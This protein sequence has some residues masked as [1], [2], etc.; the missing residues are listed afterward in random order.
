MFQKNKSTI[1]TI[2]GGVILILLIYALQSYLVPF[3]LAYVLAYVVDP[4][5][6]WIQEKGRVR[7][8]VLAVWVFLFG[9][10]GFVIGVG[11]LVAPLLL[12]EFD[13]LRS[14]VENENLLGNAEF[15]FVEELKPLLEEWLN[16]S[17]TQE[18][19]NS[20]NSS[21]LGEGMLGALEAVFSVFGGLLGGL[22]NAFT[23]LLYFFFILVSFDGW[24]ERIPQ[25]IPAN[26][27]ES[28]IDHFKEM[29]QVVRRY[30]RGQS[31]VVL[32][33]AIL[34]SI[35]F[36]ITGLPLAI[37]VGVIAGLLNFVPYLQLLIILPLLWL[38]GIQVIETGGSFGW[39]F[40][41]HLGVV[42]VVQLIQEAVL[43]PKIL[44]KTVGLHPAII[45]LALTI[46][47][48]IMGVTGMILAIPITS[49]ITVYYQ[50]LL[51][52]VEK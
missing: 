51:S 34:F 5:V 18:L 31:Q 6:D 43:N 32:V 33:V 15:W 4:M 24:T 20:S 25:L 50:R 26:I 1:Y 14:W 13:L 27:R 19:L 29:E 9:L 28:F 41:G 45:L 48:G 17:N 16:S 22:F 3:F 42:L 38:S 49:L 39:I 52:K 47:G 30:F 23:F 21:Q 7:N 36:K 46:F 11:A 8:R 40:V 44:G 10:V 2:S 37:L 12:E 35:G